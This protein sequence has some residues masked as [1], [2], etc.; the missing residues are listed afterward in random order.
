MGRSSSIIPPAQ[1]ILLDE[2][3]EYAVRHDELA[4]SS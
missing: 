1:V 2:K 3:R 4:R